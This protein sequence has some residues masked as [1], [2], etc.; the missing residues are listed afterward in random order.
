[1]SNTRIADILGPWQEPEF[2]SGLI[3]RVRSA[4]QTPIKDLSNQV[5]ATLLRQRIATNEVLAEAVKRL[6]SGFDDETE[7]YEGELAAAVQAENEK[8]AET[9]ILNIVGDDPPTPS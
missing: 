1:M 2:Q 9:S 5:L 3:D 4:W 8:V 7:L 6:K